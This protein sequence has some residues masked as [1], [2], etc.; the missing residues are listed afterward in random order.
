MNIRQY[1]T[2][3]KGVEVYECLKGILP[4]KRCIEQVIKYIY[5][6]DSITEIVELKYD[7][8][9]KNKK[10]ILSNVGQYDSMM[11]YKDCCP[12][13]KKVYFETNG[14]IVKDNYIDKMINVDDDLSCDREQYIVFVLN[15]GIK[16]SDTYYN[17]GSLVIVKHLPIKC[18]TMYEKHIAKILNI[19]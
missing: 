18:L 1:R 10:E 4:T 15:D 7:D 8:Y 12:H 11:S 2:I 14:D 13:A 16:I 17:R 9:I 5:N 3:K 6:L 19:K